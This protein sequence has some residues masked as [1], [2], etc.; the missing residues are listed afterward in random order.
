MS[1]FDD[2]TSIELAEL[3]EEF[4]H[5]NRKAQEVYKKITDLKANFVI[6]KRLK[7]HGKN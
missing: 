1:F 6:N 2:L 3:E 4:Q 7:L 5:Y